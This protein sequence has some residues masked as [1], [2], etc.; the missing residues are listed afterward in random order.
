MLWNSWVILKDYFCIRFYCREWT[1]KLVL[2]S[3]VY[4]SVL[5]NL[6]NRLNESLKFSDV[7]QIQHKAFSVVKNNLTTLENYEALFLDS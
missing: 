7:S 2:K 3:L 4:F 5:V 1:L 6:L